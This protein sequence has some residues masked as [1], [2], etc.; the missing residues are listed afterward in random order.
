[1]GNR[2]RMIAPIASAA[3]GLTGPDGE[4]DPVIRAMPFRG[5]T[6]VATALSILVL[7]AGLAGQTTRLGAAGEA[8]RLA[9]W[10]TPPALVTSPRFEWP[11]PV[12]P[13]LVDDHNAAVRRV[14]A[15]R[16]RRHAV[17]PFV[18]RVERAGARVIHASPFAPA[19]IVAGPPEAL[20]RVAAL[21]E[22]G[23]AAPAVPYRAEQDISGR[24]IRADAVAALPTP[25]GPVTGKG[26][27]VCVLEAESVEQANPYTVPGVIY[28]QTPPA[29]RYGKHPTA[30]AGIIAGQHPVYRG[31]AP[32]VTLLNANAGT[33]TQ[34]NILAATDWAIKQG[35][36]TINASF[37]SNSS[38]VQQLMDHYF[39]HVVRNL[40]VNFIKGAGN[41]GNSTGYVVSPG[42]GYNSV[43]VGN[44]RD[45]KT[46][47][48]WDDDVNPSSGYL[49]PTTG[50]PKPEVVAP[51]TSL[52]GNLHTSPWIGAIGSGGSYAGPQ[53]NAIAAL[54]MERDPVLKLWPEAIKAVLLATAWHKIEPALVGDRDG[55]GQLN[56]FAADA[57]VRQGTNRLRYGD[58]T[59]GS[60]DPKGNLDVTI[61]LEPHSET[62]AVVSWDSDP[63]TT[64]PYSPNPLRMDLD[65]EVLDPSQKRVA[66]ANDRKRG[67][68]I[69]RFVPHIGGTYTFRLVRARFDGVKEPYA[70]AV[71]QAHDAAVSSITGPSTLALG[72]TAKFPLTDSYHPG[73][74][75][76]AAASLSGGGYGQG[77]PLG[78]NSVP[79]VPDAVTFLIL[80]AGGAGIFTGYQG[81]LDGTG[82]AT[83][84]VNVLNLKALVGLEL[85]QA[86]VILDPSGPAGLAGITPP[87][88][89]R[90][91]P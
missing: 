7:T 53:G 2:D 80:T 32:G 25:P 72:K 71:T 23:F 58:L 21:P 4:E 89:A 12:D 39:D 62:R 78:N 31:M 34:A 67:F 15:E 55:V 83:L 26:V 87:I 16:F 91:V 28:Y 68:E 74:A 1:M 46:P 3:T 14:Y 85:T 10:Y 86:A 59:V 66:A 56:A 35:A 70:L 13:A 45:K 50:H 27:K 60:F 18:A 90:F 84:E 63:A 33:F 24:T 29:V 57:V 77:F 20:A 22:V 17:D 36:N 8:P 61:G 73:R 41:N 5:R 38:G 37:G 51:G 69:V 52:T 11:R 48:W 19:A 9:V 79:L 76:V 30:V 88:A 40:N 6:S 47:H 65:L 54:L 44:S 75:Y 81:S 64:S 42:L 82:K 49:D 43:T